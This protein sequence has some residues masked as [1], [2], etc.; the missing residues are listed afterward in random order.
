MSSQLPKPWAYLTTMF[1]KLCSVLSVEELPNRNCFGITSIASAMQRA[2]RVA[3]PYP[4]YPDPPLLACLHFLVIFPCATF[5]R[6]VFF[7]LFS[8][9]FWG[10]NLTPSR[11]KKT[12]GNYH[13]H[14]L[15]YC[16]KIFWPRKSRIRCRFVIHAEIPGSGIRN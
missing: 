13:A 14:T 16:R 5:L 15:K 2:Q 7:F 6:F 4:H 12:T 1:L 11:P 3:I 8:K 10:L 9:D